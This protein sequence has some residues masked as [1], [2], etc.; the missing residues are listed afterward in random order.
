MGEL[1]LQGVPRYG[2]EIKDDVLDKGI[3]VEPVFFKDFFNHLASR[4]D[5]CVRAVLVAVDLH[6]GLFDKVEFALVGI[7]VGGDHD[8][9]K[10]GPKFQGTMVIQEEFPKRIEEEIL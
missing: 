6:T 8:G 9:K 10:F 1:Y 2:F 4:Q 7:L 5:Q 3:D